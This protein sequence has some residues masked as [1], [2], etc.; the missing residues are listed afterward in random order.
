MP[1]QAALVS[2][3]FEAM[4]R[5]RQA[6]MFVA[7]L[8]AA[9]PAWAQ[10]PKTPTSPDDPLS[11]TLGWVEAAPG[12]QAAA[13]ESASPAI[14][15]PQAAVAMPSVAGPSPQAAAPVTQPLAPAPQ[16]PASMESVAPP[17]RTAA[18]APPKAAPAQPR[19]PKQ[20]REERRASRSRPRGDSARDHIANQLN[21]QE[22]GS[23]SPGPAA[24]P[25][26]AAPR[27]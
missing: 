22:L 7:A 12:S 23:G 25:T 16:A 14:S 9:A 21:H 18:A 2:R 13:P 4:R 1:V 8:A 20:V 11:K 17:G 19:Q 15:T 27:R 10:V 6:T 3:R 24:S 26:A 5:L